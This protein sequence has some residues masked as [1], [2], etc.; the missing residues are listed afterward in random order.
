MYVCMYGVERSAGYNVE[1]EEGKVNAGWVCMVER[2]QVLNSL[3]EKCP[4]VHTTAPDGI[5]CAH[6]YSAYSTIS[7]LKLLFCLYYNGYSAGTKSQAA[8]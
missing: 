4:R 5:R 2:K 8:L 7:R 6:P 1:S 3:C